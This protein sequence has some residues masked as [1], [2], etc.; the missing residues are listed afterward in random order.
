[1]QKRRR[2]RIRVDRRLDQG[3]FHERRF[4]QGGVFEGVGEFGGGIGEC[5]EADASV[6]GE[7]G[8]AEYSHEAGGEKDD[9]IVG[10]GEAVCR[11]G[12]GWGE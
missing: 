2:V 4:G 7:H 10:R 9:E 1:M 11:R 6:F 5:V 12:S 3:A 8:D